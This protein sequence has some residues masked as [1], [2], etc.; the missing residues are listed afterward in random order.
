MSAI[1]SVIRANEKFALDYDPT[2]VSPRP[3]MHLAVLT[4]MDTRLES[5]GAGH[6]CGRRA[7]DTECG[8]HRD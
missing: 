4:C 8:R 6:R 3:R 5:R 7:L 1:E 2:Q